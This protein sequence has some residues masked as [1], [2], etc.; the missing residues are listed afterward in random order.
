MSSVLSDTD[1]VALATI[2]A[3]E[4][5]EYFCEKCVKIRRREDGLSVP[6]I[7]NS[8][9]K[10]I[11]REIE[12]QE[13][14]KKPVRMVILKARQMGVSTFIEIY[15]LW[16]LLKSHNVNAI[17]IAHEREA[18]RYILDISR[19]AFENL[20]K[21]FTTAM[22]L[23]AE[24]LTK[25]DIS[26]NNGCSLYISSSES[27]QP[28]MSRTIQYIHLS[29][30]AFYED[31][32]TLVRSL[33]SACPEVPGTVIF[34]ESTGRAPVGFFYDVYTQA[35]RGKSAYTPIFLPWYEMAEYR[36][37]PPPG[38]TPAPVPDLPDLTVEQLMWR[39]YVIANKFFGDEDAFR[40]MFPATEQ[41]AFVRDSANVFPPEAVY[42]RL[43]EIEDVR[44]LDG[45]LAR[46]TLDSSVEFVASPDGALRVFKEPEE[47]RRYVIGADVGSGVAVNKVGDYS[48]ADVLDAET[49]EQVA[50]YHTHI[51]PDVFGQELFLLGNWYNGALLAV[52]VE[53][54]GLAV[55]NV[56]RDLGYPML[57][58][59][60]VFD[61]INNDWVNKLG[62]STNQKTK[63]FIID[64]LRAAF[65][66][67]EVT[68]NHKGTLEE[69]LSFVRLSDKND[70]MGAVPGAFDDQVISLAI[71]EQVRREML[72]VLPKQPEEKE[73]EPGIPPGYEEAM[74]YRLEKM[75]RE[76]V[77]PILGVFY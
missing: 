73:P 22:K 14:T 67:G 27:K 44:Y 20:P 62:W 58:R 29:E 51:E 19:F 65:R 10:R 6:F 71:A 57:Y 36:M 9:Q 12:R 21:W 34:L 75:K 39:E 76:A 59:R 45:Y 43:R 70:K 4:S 61:K 49:G 32:D 30:C 1:I 77:H 15:I 63:K 42:A 64:G 52:E 33:F 69:M 60:R 35:T 72:V 17:E 68:V 74:R 2:R 66:N 41:E 55:I 48:S 53:N 11:L 38:Y 56:L 50:H 40:N 25:Y 46:K 16:R 47:G 18:A 24:Y 8:A 5:F 28:G 3:L 23:D 26:L 37:E 31:A 7:L 54:H 13:A